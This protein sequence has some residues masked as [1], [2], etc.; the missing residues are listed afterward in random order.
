[1]VAIELQEL[2]DYWTSK[3]P[4]VTITFYPQSADGIYRGK[5]MTNSDSLDLQADTISELINTPLHV[6]P[7]LQ[8]ASACVSLARAF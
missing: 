6:Y 5:M 4:Y 8:I 3:Y 2:K 1:M 7:I